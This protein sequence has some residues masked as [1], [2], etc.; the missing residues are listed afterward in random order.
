MNFGSNRERFVRVGKN[1]SLLFFFSRTRQ[2]E[3]GRSYYLQNCILLRPQQ[4]VAED[5][6]EGETTRNRGKKETK[7]EIFSIS[8]PVQ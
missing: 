5:V 6:V 1:V 8:L 4:A 3:Q 2:Q 7:N